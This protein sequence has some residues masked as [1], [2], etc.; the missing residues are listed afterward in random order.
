MQL[1]TSCHDEIMTSPP[2]II[3]YSPLNII[4]YNY[5]NHYPKETTDS[6]N[7]ILE[8]LDERKVGILSHIYL[9]GT[10]FTRYQKIREQ[11]NKWYEEEEDQ[12]KGNEINILIFLLN[13]HGCTI[14]KKIRTNKLRK[15]NN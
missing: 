12:L 2:N 1:N 3:A 13:M 15:V 9:N 5:Y 6:V 8:R 4:A 11:W 10:Q 14:A 7:F